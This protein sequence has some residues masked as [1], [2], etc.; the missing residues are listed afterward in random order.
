MADRNAGEQ[1]RGHG[2]HQQCA[3]NGVRQRQGVEIG[4]TLVA[5][6]PEIHTQAGS[7]HQ[8]GIGRVNGHK[9]K[10]EGPRR[11]LARAKPW[12]ELS[13]EKNLDRHLLDQSVERNQP[14]PKA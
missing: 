5:P 9:E 4:L 3:E 11:S 13:M 2:L 8:P 10:G 7:Q 1:P 6:R 12:H 14:F